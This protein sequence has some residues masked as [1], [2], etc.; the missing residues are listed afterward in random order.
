MDVEHTNDILGKKIS[1]FSLDLLKKLSSSQN[2]VYSPASIY[3]ALAM[4]ALGSRGESLQQFQ[5]LLQFTNSNDLARLTHD[6]QN[7]LL[8]T[9]NGITTSIANKVFSGLK[10]V[11]SEYVNLITQ[12]F[13][14]AFENVDFSTSFEQI[15]LQINQWVSTTTNNKI[16]DL[17]SQGTLDALTRMV[18]VNAIYFKGTWGTTFDQK[19]THKAQFNLEYEQSGKHASVD[20][21]N[22]ETKFDYFETGDYQYISIPYKDQSYRM[23]IVLPTKPLE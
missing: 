6:L 12:H 11:N 3:I 9:G 2:L 17:L 4:A 13:K 20:M 8:A 19:K 18:L 1:S 5:T 16:N 21:M 7:N 14:S 23:E 10:E 15:R 22:L